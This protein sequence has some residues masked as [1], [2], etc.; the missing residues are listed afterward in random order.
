GKEQAAQVLL[1]LQT[2]KKKSHAEQYIFQKRTPTTSEPFGLIESS[3]LYAEL[4]LTNSKTDS[5]KEVSLEMNAGTQEEGQ[6]GTNPG[7]AFVSETQSSH[8]V[9]ARPNLDHMDLGVTETSSQPN[10]EQIDEEFTMM[11]YPSVQENLKLPTEGEVRL[12]EPASSAGTL[13]S[14]QNL[15]KDLSFIN[16][17]LA[18][19]S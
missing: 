13:S 9:Y 10:P 15:D 19:K 4:G 6:D 18:E 7:D 8:V 12:E 14:L 16:Q 2:T 11:A 17:F 1:N 5:D 3:P